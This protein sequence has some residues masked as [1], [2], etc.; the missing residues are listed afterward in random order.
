MTPYPV[1]SDSGPRDSDH[2]HMLLRRRRGP[3]RSL[4]L[5]YVALLRARPAPGPH[6]PSLR[7]FTSSEATDATSTSKLDV[8][9]GLLIRPRTQK[10]VVA[11]DVRVGRVFDAE[12]AR[13]LRE[14]V[15]QEPVWKSTSASGA[16]SHFSAMTRPSWLGRAV[17]DR[18][19]YAIEQASRRWRGGRRGD[20]GRTRRKI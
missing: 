7:A 14:L 4:A 3:S 19:R 13:P 11:L 12:V 8:D 9:L 2:D 16:L 18:H 6:T 1:D 15:A 10:L 20:S 17:R 5:G